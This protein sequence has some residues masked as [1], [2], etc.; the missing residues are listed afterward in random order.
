MASSS[1]METKE[2]GTYVLYLLCSQALLL[3]VCIL[4]HAEP[5]YVCVGGIISHSWIPLAEANIPRFPKKQLVAFK[6]MNIMFWW[7]KQSMS[8][9][10]ILILSPQHDLS[11]TQF[12]LIVQIN[13]SRLLSLWKCFHNRSW[14]Q[15]LSIEQIP[16]FV[17][18]EISSS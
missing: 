13:S 8:P 9:N 18:F 6:Q 3:W 15:S 1:Q 5:V 2:F 17:A 16:W 4:A 7:N 10:A 14:S 12:K 11:D